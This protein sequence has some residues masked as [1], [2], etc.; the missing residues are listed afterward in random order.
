M[1]QINGGLMPRSRVN[2]LVSGLRDYSIPPEV[3]VY[4]A[5]T[6]ELL[7]IEQPT[8]FETLCKMKKTVK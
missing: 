7:R 2:R 6:G 4:S 8:D 1:A 3:K 5:A